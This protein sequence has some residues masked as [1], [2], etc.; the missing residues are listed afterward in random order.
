[1]HLDLEQVNA[2]VPD[3]RNR[4]MQLEKLFAQP[5]WR[6]VVALA[7]QNAAV[8]LTQAAVASSWDNNRLAYGN[9]IAWRAIQN[10]EKDTQALYSEKAMQTL[11]QQELA[12]LSEENELE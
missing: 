6:V 4:Y 11:N 9:H 7:T 10:L 3:D 2:L 5:G 1:M 8:A 12:R